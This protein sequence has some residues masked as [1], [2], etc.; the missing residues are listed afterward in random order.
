MQSC[1]NKLQKEKRQHNKLFDYFK[2]Y[3][4]SILYKNIFEPINLLT[5]VTRQPDYQFDWLSINM[6]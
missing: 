2:S 3:Y 5:A 6:H 1:W 4:N